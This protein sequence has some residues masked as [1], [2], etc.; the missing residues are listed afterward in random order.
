MED[1]ED[2]PGRTT[3]C[4]YLPL[5]LLA[6]YMGLDSRP[7]PNDRVQTAEEVSG[8]SV[9]L[10]SPRSTKGGR[11]VGRPSASWKGRADHPRAEGERRGNMRRGSDCV[12]ERQRHHRPP[13]SS[14]HSRPSTNI[15]VMDFLAGICRDS[16]EAYSYSQTPAAL[17]WLSARISG[18]LA[19]Q[20]ELAEQFKINPT[21]CH[22]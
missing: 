10:G 2:V 18:S 17:G 13:A 5:H 20:A 19:Q 16:G 8:P 14:N 6:G 15:R 3:Q 12:P 11:S 1:E 9:Q 7:Q 22:V 4:S 21:R